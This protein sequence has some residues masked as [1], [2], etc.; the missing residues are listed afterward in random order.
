MRRGVRRRLLLQ[1]ARRSVELE[2]QAWPAEIEH[3]RLELSSHSGLRRR[4][5]TCFCPRV[6][7]HGLATCRCRRRCFFQR[8]VRNAASNT[9]RRP[10]VRG[11]RAPRNRREPDGR[12]PRSWREPDGSAPLR[13]NHMSRRVVARAA[14]DKISAGSVFTC[15]ER[16][17]SVPF[18]SCASTPRRWLPSA[19][20]SCACS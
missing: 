6:S 18:F 4:S 16:A 15:N 20:R 13:K 10:G 7:L 14:R 17:F 12:T 2:L 11:R 19:R 1:C 8:E 9:A 5:G 3:V